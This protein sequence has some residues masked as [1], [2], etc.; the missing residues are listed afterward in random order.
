MAWER[1]LFETVTTLSPTP[2]MHVAQ[3]IVGRPTHKSKLLCT[4][5]LIRLLVRGYDAIMYH[6][7]VCD[8]ARIHV[9]HVYIYAVLKDGRGW[10]CG[11]G[12]QRL[13]G[14]AGRVCL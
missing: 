10:G 13:A 3:R 6:R 4:E 7:P 2:F 9:L 8:D 11:T 12:C 14:F 1:G 5:I